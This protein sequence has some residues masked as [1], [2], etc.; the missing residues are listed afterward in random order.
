M[1]NWLKNREKL[2]QEDKRQDFITKREQ[3][4]KKFGK[5][6][7]FDLFNITY[8]KVNENDIQKKYTLIVGW[9]VNR[10]KDQKNV[11]FFKKKNT[12][13]RDIASLFGKFI[14][15]KTQTSEENLDKNFTTPIVDRDSISNIQNNNK[16]VQLSLFD[17]FGVVEKEKKENIQ[18]EENECNKE[19]IAIKK[20][21]SW[22]TNINNLNEDEYKYS[23]QRIHN[24]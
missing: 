24:N 23:R 14:Y 22:N 3:Q 21:Y 12:I 19:N 15:I 7:I 18:K 16:S 9:L 5:K 10:L 1:E 6:R 11:S 13:Y 4:S 2:L 20:A 8:N 17:T